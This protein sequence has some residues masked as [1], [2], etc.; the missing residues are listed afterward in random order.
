MTN[1]E[2]I[3]IIKTAIAQVEWDYPMDYAA[4][5]DMAIKAL[6][7]QEPQVM[8]MQNWEANHIEKMPVWVEWN[9]SAKGECTDNGKADG[10]TIL[11]IDEFVDVLC[12]G[13]RC[14]TS[15][16]TEEQRK[17]VKWDD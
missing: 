4:A 6:K 12:F 9:K 17:A 13:G 16:P 2:A 15:R 14:W 3:D 1:Q 10:W 8:T 11:N 7:A 5:F